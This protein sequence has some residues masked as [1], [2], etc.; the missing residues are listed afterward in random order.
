M[1][2]EP[3]SLGLDFDSTQTTTMQP[4]KVG[5]SKSGAPSG[6]DQADDASAPPTEPSVESPKPL[7]PEP[8]I[9]PER[10]NTGGPPRVTSS[11]FIYSPAAYDLLQVKL[12]EQELEERMTLRRKENEKRKERDLVCSWLSSLQALGLIVVQ[13]VEKDRK[14]FEDTQESERVKQAQSR[15]VQEQ[16]NR[17]RK[18]NAQ[19]KMDKTE[20]RL[21]DVDKP[22]RG[23]NHATSSSPD[24]EGPNVPQPHASG[25]PRGGSPRGRGRGRG[26]G[27]ARGGANKGVGRGLGTESGEKSP[28][29]TTPTAASPVSA[30]STQAATL[31]SGSA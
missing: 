2:N 18:Q 13:E 6:P 29:S 17:T 22:A 31:A 14:A 8:Y 11:L 3:N 28:Q 26:R 15:Q 12:S 4:D 19:N 23:W 5:T 16:V 10:V 9:N 24:T 30:S 1:A 25:W 27:Q 20:S 7:K 21:W